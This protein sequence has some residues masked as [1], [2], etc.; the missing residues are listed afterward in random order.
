MLVT[1]GAGLIGIDL[2]LNLCKL[3]VKKIICIDLKEK[4]KIFDNLIIE[5]FQKDINDI[6]VNFFTKYDINVV[7]HHA[8]TFERTNET[9][10]F[11]EDNYNNNIKLSN[12]IGTVCKNLER[13]VFTSSYLIYNSEL[14]TFNNP[15]NYPYIVVENTEIKPRNICGAAKLLHEIEILSKFD[16]NNFTIITPRIFKVYGPRQCGKFGGTIINRWINSLIENEDEPITVY[17]KE[18]MF[19]FIYSEEIAYGLVILGTIKNTGVVN[20]GRGKSHKIS[21]ILDILKDFS[22]ELI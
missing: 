18:G 4:P 5:Y 16:S 14:Y 8:A 3:K 10:E 2:I 17:G 15:R 19:D 9:E 1:G 13:V 20:I 22:Q 12:H 6:T 11:W 21:D 7:F